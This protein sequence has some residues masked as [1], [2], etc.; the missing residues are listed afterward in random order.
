[1]VARVIATV[2][3]VAMSGCFVAD[4]CQPET[5]RC[6]GSI[7]EYCQPHGGGIYGSGYVHSSSPT[8]DAVADC[9]ANRC[10]AD[11]SDRAFCALDAEPT[12]VCGC[13]GTTRVSCRDGFAVEREACRTCSP[14][15]CAGGLF[16]ACTASADCAAGMTCDHDACVPTCACADGAA[17]PACAAADDRSPDPDEGAPASWTCRA[18]LCRE[19]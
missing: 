6:H 9:G 3:A 16:A 5:W 7:L 2:I 13:D 17:C 10:I 18:G 15:S 14:A 19:G 12:S 1:V 8:W 4:D 11:R